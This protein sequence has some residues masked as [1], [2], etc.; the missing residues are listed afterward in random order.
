MSEELLNK[1]KNSNLI[2]PIQICSDSPNKPKEQI[3][4]SNKQI[5]FKPVFLKSNSGSIAIP[6]FTT[7]KEF[8]KSLKYIQKLSEQYPNKTIVVITH[9]APSIKSI[10]LKYLNSDLS[11]AFASNLESF[12][13]KHSNIK[14]WCHGHIHSY[15]DYKIG[16][17]RIVCNP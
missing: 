13:L 8:K 9:H 5:L 12:I 17:C 16:D 11:P 14:L 1:I 15:N 4:N 7:E 6:L 2:F 3:I 10:P